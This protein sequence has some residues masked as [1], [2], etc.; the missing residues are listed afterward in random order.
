MMASSFIDDGVHHRLPS[1]RSFSFIAALLLMSPGI[2]PVGAEEYPLPEAVEGELRALAGDSGG[3]L[4]LEK[5]GETREKRPIT[6]AVLALPGP[7]GPRERQSILVVANL[8]GN[9]HHTTAVVLE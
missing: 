7:K 1:T 9:L 8:E 2:V 3:V 6:A 4:T 5:L